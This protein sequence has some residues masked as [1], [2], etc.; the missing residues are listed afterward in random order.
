MRIFACLGFTYVITLLAAAY[1]GFYPSLV[2]AAACLIALIFILLFVKPPFRLSLAAAALAAV[3][4]FG[5]YAV[6]YKVTEQQKLLDAL[7]CTVEGTIVS[8]AET[9]S[10]L[11]RYEVKTS[12]IQ[13][14]GVTGLPQR[15]TL[16]VTPPAGEDF[17]PH[18]T[19]SLT[20]TLQVE[21]STRQNPFGEP[22][23]SVQALR[24]EDM[25]ITGLDRSLGYYMD[26]AKNAML[27]AAAPHLDEQAAGVLEGIVFGGTNG[28]PQELTFVLNQGGVRHVFSVSGF[29]LAILAQALMLL[30]T[31][32]RVNKRLASGIVILFVLGF[33]ALVGFSYPILRAG[34]MTILAYL[35]PLFGREA[36]P[37]NSLGLAAL[38]IALIDPAS[39]YDLG[40]LLSFSATLGI[41]LCAGRISGWLTERLR[42]KNKFLKGC[43]GL[44]A[45]SLSANLFTLP[46]TILTFPSLSLVGLAA[47]ILLYPLFFLLLCGGLVFYLICLVPFLSFLAQGMGWVLTLCVT[48]LVKV[49]TVLVDLPYSSLPLRYDFV[50]LWLAAAGIIAGIGIFLSRR[51]VRVTSLCIL[52]SAVIL[53]SGVVSSLV[54]NHNVIELAVINSYNGVCVLTRD[55]S[56]ASLIVLKGDRYLAGCVSDELLGKGVARLQTVAVLPDDEEAASAAADMIASFPTSQAVYLTES[57]NSAPLAAACRREGTTP[58]PLKSAEITINSN[59]RLRLLPV[60][61]GYGATVDTAGVPV[62]IAETIASLDHLENSGSLSAAITSDADGEDLDALLSPVVVNALSE[63]QT[64]YTPKQYF[65]P[66][67]RTVTRLLFRGSTLTVQS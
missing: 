66:G 29:H 52:C 2:L 51:K 32:C 19:V 33:M 55:R 63:Q 27:S 14:P 16:S 49:L 53:L 60:P 34:I 25:K 7:P 15:V 44:F 8:Q 38:L 20:A 58:V 61:G 18:Q 5:V 65:A 4:A 43:A 50:P 57:V 36:D 59:I 42:L 12:S 9:R 47:N 17:A 26:E 45:V 40:F 56:S 1:L 13:S 23:F 31:A 35:A 48:V 3:A 54:C 37:L 39:V 22:L 11:Q 64:V 24:L 41:L 46:V 21:E 10:G 28:L 67:Q 62:G 6:Q 30:L